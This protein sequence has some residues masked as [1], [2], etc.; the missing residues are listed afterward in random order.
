MDTE[1]KNIIPFVIAQKNETL[2]CNVCKICM[3]KLHNA[4]EVNQRRS[5]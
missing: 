4:D 2:R 3:L 1:I 5:K